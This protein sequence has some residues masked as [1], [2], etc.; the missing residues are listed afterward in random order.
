MR[1]QMRRGMTAPD[2]LQPSAAAYAEWAEALR[3][4]LHR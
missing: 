1:D 2:G 4:R 3:D